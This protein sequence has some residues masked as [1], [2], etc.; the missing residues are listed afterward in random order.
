[1]APAKRIRAAVIGAGISGIVTAAHLLKEEFDV[2]V[3]ER[4]SVAGG[5]W[6]FDNRKPLEPAYPSV[7]PSE[8]QRY[9]NEIDSHKKGT[10]Q[11]EIEGLLHAP[12]GPC[13]NGLRNN[14][15]TPLLETT[16]NRFPPGTPDFVSHSVLREYIQEIATKT[17]V[18]DVTRFDTEVKNVWKSGSQWLVNAVTLKSDNSGKVS[19][20]WTL[21][22]FDSVIVASGHY[23]APRIPDIPGLADW[24][25]RWPHRVQHSKSYRGPDDFKEKV[26]MV[27]LTGYHYFRSNW[28]TEDKQNFLLI[29]ASV[30]SSDIAREVGPIA[31][32][33]Y[34]SHRNGA[35]DLPANFLPENAVRVDEV[36]SFEIRRDSNTPLADQDPIC[37]TIT[38]TSGHKLR[39]IH[40]VILCTGYHITLPFLRHLH[41]DTTAP[42]NA[43]EKILV[44]DGTQFHNLHKD[45]FYIPDPTLI[46]IGVPFFTATFTL[47]EFQ[48]MVVAK[49]LSGHAKLPSE[50]EMRKEYRRRVQ[51]KGVGKGFHSLRGVEVEYV[52]ELIKWVNED[53][54]RL[55]MGG[56]VLKGHTEGWHRAR[57]EH[58]ERVEALFGGVRR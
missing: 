44:T 40:H 57:R 48:A 23:H 32:K 43:D 30:S 53:L 13:Y 24:K 16:L 11:I 19:R 18:L 52:E 15:S 35:Y 54:R 25:Q 14:V 27:P 20:S 9:Y 49:V 41:S 8:A 26:G 17:G 21:E 42:Q 3:F 39:D 46:F 58:L 47:F 56:K 29:G 50:E 10:L 33:I 2:T 38:L 22:E 34:Q 45:I 36:S 12:P 55:G 1:M 28:L 37:S 6:V 5:V 51:E 4:S 31:N 7:L